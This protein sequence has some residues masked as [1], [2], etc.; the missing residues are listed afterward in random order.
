MMMMMMMIMN[1]YNNNNF[2]PSSPGVISLASCSR[3]T[4]GLLEPSPT[5]SPSTRGWLTL[6]GNDDNNG[7]CN[8]DDYSDY[9]GLPRQT[10]M[11]IMVL[12]GND[13]ETTLSGG[14]TGSSP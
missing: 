4:P 8:D 9:C 5:C 6:A 14:S 3:S 13:V 12:N 10:M 11:M 7:K 2:N 1:D